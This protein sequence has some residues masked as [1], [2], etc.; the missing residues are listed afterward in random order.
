MH[1]E[2]RAHGGVGKERLPHS[3]GEFDGPFGRMCADA[4]EHIDQVGIGIHRLQPARHQQTLDDADPLRAELARSESSRPG[5]LPPGP[6]SEPYVNVSAHTAPERALGTLV[7]CLSASRRVFL[8]GVVRP[9]LRRPAPL[10]STLITSAS[11]LLRVHPSLDRGIGTLGLR[12]HRSRLLPCH[13]QPS[14]HVPC[15]GLA[16]ALASL[17]PDAAYPV[18]RSPVRSSACGYKHAF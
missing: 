18:S 16:Q 7:E 13:P 11:S 10:R 2:V 14:S 1:T 12:V 9:T 15:H 8:R 3:R 4:L 5:E 6:L 17:T